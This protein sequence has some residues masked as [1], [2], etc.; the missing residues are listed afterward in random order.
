MSRVAATYF[1][2]HEGETLESIKQYADRHISGYQAVLFDIGVEGGDSGK[3][4][5]LS[6]SNSFSEPDWITSVRVLTGL[7][8][9]RA[10][11]SFFLDAV[12]VLEESGRVFAI[13]F[14]QGHHAAKR[15]PVVHTF[16]KVCVANLADDGFRGVKTRV[17]G[18]TPRTVSQRSSENSDVST[19]DFPDD[20]FAM[21]GLSASLPG[22]STDEKPFLAEGGIGVKYLFDDDAE[23]LREI[24]QGFL[25]AWNGGEYT[26]TSVANHEHF[27]E[28]TDR[29]VRHRMAIEM[30]NA[31]RNKDYSK[32]TL[33]VPTRDVWEST[34]L[35][36]RLNNTYIDFYPASPEACV[37]VLYE[38]I[39]AGKE[40][41]DFS[42]KVTMQDGTKEHSIPFRDLVT[43]EFRQE[44][45]NLYLWDGG[46]WYKGRPD[47]VDD[48]CKAALAQIDASRKFVEKI[49]LPDFD[50]KLPPGAE[51]SERKGEDRYVLD[52]LASE[53]VKCVKSVHHKKFPPTGMPKAE[54][55]DAFVD[56]DTLLFIKRGV[57][58]SALAEVTSQAIQA[59]KFGFSNDEFHDWANREL[60]LDLEGRTFREG[61]FKIVIAIMAPT[62]SQDP[63]KWSPRAL[64]RVH[65]FFRSLGPMRLNGALVVIKDTEPKK[66]RPDKDKRKK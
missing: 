41:S 3:G 13:S 4:M 52:V 20:V 46:T 59:C 36:Y 38:A 56:D 66:P 2:L 31:I 27:V 37:D 7:D 16:G 5:L 65:A 40:L 45:G 29:I 39:K 57:G 15:L 14:R 50:G 63:A 42:L 61:N 49:Q 51:E 58:F 60:G 22:T 47:W 54:I 62:S 64:E 24:L 10:P 34:S 30:E 26:N 18:F 55:C 48:Q 1:L 28:E 6:K 33:S 35:A 11:P 53:S 9:E 44:G 25:E 43:F 19:F 12:L 21:A 32:F 17:F 8:I 23:T